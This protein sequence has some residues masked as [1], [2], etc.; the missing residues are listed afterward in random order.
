MSNNKNNTLANNAANAP[1]VIT[2]DLWKRAGITLDTSKDAATIARQNLK[3]SGAAYIP[4]GTDSDNLLVIMDGVRTNLDASENARRNACVMLA[5]IDASREFR[6]ALNANGKPYTST[7]ALARD[8]F[9]T[10]EKSTV[11]NYIGAGRSVF[12]PAIN[13]RF[14]K[15]GSRVMLEQTP[16][17]AAVLKGVI[18][19][20]NTRDAALKAVQD[21]IKKQ[22]KLTKRAAQDIVK[23]LTKPS[24]DGGRADNERAMARARTEISEIDK[25]NKVLK[26]M[27]DYIP[28]TL[29]DTESGDIHI[30]IP[31]QL[32]ADFKRTLQEA[33]V[34]TDAHDAQ[35]VLKALCKVICG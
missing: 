29:R 13:G 6:K 10:L 24:N 34:S 33:V 27:L 19:D 1:I 11:A 31:E 3:S 32:K 5:A 18:A 7:L 20:D 2:A 21:I 14:G 17:N 4:M 28:Q 15:A 30:T 22:G 23:G 26:K 25:Y 12:L 16:S 35:I 9:P 8:L